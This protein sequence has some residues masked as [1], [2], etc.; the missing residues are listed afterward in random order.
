[1]GVAGVGTR[2]DLVFAFARFQSILSDRW[3]LTPGRR[4]CS[5][6]AGD[7]PL[8]TTSDKKIVLAPQKH[9]HDVRSIRFIQFFG[10]R[11]VLESVLRCGIA[12]WCC[13]HHRSRPVSRSHYRAGRRAVEKDSS[14]KVKQLQEAR[15]KVDRRSTTGV[16]FVADLRLLAAAVPTIAFLAKDGKVRAKKA[17]SITRPAQSSKNSLLERCND[18]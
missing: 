17:L 18:R 8:L 15:S 10:D 2:L 5:P 1:M 7:P 4:I 12:A 14:E 6:S 11:A 13:Y 16:K 9:F 3:R